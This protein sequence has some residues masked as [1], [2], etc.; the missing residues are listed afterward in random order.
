[1][2]VFITGL[3]KEAFEGTL[4]GI[5]EGTKL[6]PGKNSQFQKPKA[7]HLNPKTPKPPKPLNS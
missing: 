4:I 3:G 6:N 1:M 2:V 5:P 7:P